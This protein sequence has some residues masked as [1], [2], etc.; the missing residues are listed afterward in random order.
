MAGVTAMLAEKMGRGVGN[1]NPELYQ[2]A[3]SAPQALHDVT[4]ATSGVISCDVNTPSMCNN[5][6]PSSTGPNGGQAG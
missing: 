2:M 5:S 4:I 3:V 6:T 1:L